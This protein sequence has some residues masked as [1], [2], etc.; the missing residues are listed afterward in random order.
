MSETVHAVGFL[1]LVAFVALGVISLRGWLARRDPATGWAAASFGV[2]GAVVLLARA[3]PQHPNGI[4]EGALLRFLIVLL[5]V[6]PYFLF[7]FTNSFGPPSR[8]LFAGVSAGT[9]ALS[10]WTFALPD[11]PEAGEPRS[12]AF[13][14][15]LVAFVVHWT[16]L[17][18]A[19][20]VR[21]IRAGRGSR[22]SRAGGCGCS[23]SRR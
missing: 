12:F 9:V 10:I 19:S 18:I 20:A 22:A 4:F 17:S 1:N 8:R 7:R 3:V 2:L 21:L 14:A 23:W 16:V 6:F 15:Y 13:N 5:V 11:I